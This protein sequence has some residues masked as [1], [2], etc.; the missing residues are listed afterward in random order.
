MRVAH[1][2]AALLIAAC[3]AETHAPLVATDV[4]ITA[5]PPGMAMSAAYMSLTNNSARTISIS[6]V[7]SEQYGSVQ[8]HETTVSDG[9]ARMRALAELVIPPGETA[10]LEPGGKHLMLTRPIGNGDNVSLQLF[11][12][13][14]LLLVVNA[15]LQRRDN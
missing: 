14:N 5:P 11:D 15:S 3:G 12:G 2:A 1:V 4:V 8:L 7:T 13:D 6:R 10:T 9:V